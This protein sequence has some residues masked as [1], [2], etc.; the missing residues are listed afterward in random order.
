MG[1]R[2]FRVV[3]GLSEF[4]CFGGGGGFRVEGLGFRVQGSGVAEV[5]HA[6]VM[7]LGRLGAQ[8]RAQKGLGF[9]V[10]GFRVYNL[11]FRVRGAILLAQ[12]HL[13][14]LRPY[15]D[16]VG[17]HTPSLVEKERALGA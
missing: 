6:S 1:A 17:S 12:T 9:R 10:L 15:S 13:R 14:L 7:T 4:W 11:G 2:V 8:H 16:N 5:T 3:A